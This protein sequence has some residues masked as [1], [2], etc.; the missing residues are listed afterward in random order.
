MT[1]RTLPTGEVEEITEAEA[2]QKLTRHTKHE[3]QPHYEWSP[4][5]SYLYIYRWND[6]AEAN[7]REVM[8]PAE[9]CSLMAFLE[10]N[11][12]SKD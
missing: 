12:P 9:V 8:R 3:D 1:K 4:C 6:Y 2:R 10:K 11:P 5:G 7:E